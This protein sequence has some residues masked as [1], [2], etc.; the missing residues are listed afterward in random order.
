MTA[1]QSVGV[2]QEAIVIKLNE[3]IDVLRRDLILKD[4]II[5]KL[6]VGQKKDS[7]IESNVDGQVGQK[8]ADVPPNLQRPL[9]T[10]TKSPIVAP[11]GIFT[12]HIILN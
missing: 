5:K 10:T 9:V 7:P 12:H 6:E 3:T 2:G 4:E 1:M 11:P 8:V